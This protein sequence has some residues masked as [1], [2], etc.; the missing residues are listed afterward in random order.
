MKTPKVG[1]IGAGFAGVRALRELSGVGLDVTL[2]EPRDTTVMLP[3]LPDVAGGWLESR[4]LQVP[5]ADVLPI[6]VRHDQRAVT[7]IN[8]ARKEVVVAGE[9]CVFDAILIASGSQ[10]AACPLNSP[11]GAAHTLGS[12]EDAQHLRDAFIR[13]LWQ[14]PQPH[15]LVV[16]GGYTG[17]ELAS[18]LATHAAAVC[19]PCRVTVVESAPGITPFLPPLQRKRIA[20]ALCASGVDVV[21]DTRVTA[22]D[23]RDAQV[24]ATHYQDVFFCWTVGSVFAVPEV[25]GEVDRLAD[26]RLRVAPDLSLPAYPDIFVAGDAAAVT[27]RGTALRK[28]VNFAWYG[29]RVA[30]R[31]IKARLRG[32]PTQ[33][34]CPIDL[35]W[36]IPLRTTSVGLLFGCLWVGGRLGRRLHYL[37]CDIRTQARRRSL[38]LS[39]KGMV[40][41]PVVTAIEDGTAVGERIDG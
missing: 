14:A 18:T 7:A 29:G 22:W 9:S 39:R 4:L 41:C 20:A 8:L 1:V 36:V 12:L 31:N 28:A 33:P 27:H 30:A 11:G 10:A 34:Y 37:M 35:G 25:C 38:N 24:G 5:L 21:V 15:V 40:S 17:L 19:R 3:A 26:G 13:Y 23:G 2:F 16:G 32:A 6:G